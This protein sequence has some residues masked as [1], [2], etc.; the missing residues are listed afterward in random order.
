[1][2]RV[3]RFGT[4]KGEIEV[5]PWPPAP[6]NHS[7]KSDPLNTSPQYEPLRYVAFRLV[8]AP[9]LSDKRAIW[10]QKLDKIER[11]TPQGLVE[12]ALSRWHSGTDVPALESLSDC[13][14]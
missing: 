14:H 5:S 7:R 12:E 4:R 10:F 3:A 2:I 6:R 1:M 9:L 11:K 13:N 8:A